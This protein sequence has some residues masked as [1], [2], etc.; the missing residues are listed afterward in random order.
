MSDREKIKSAAPNSLLYRWLENL[1]CPRCRERLAIE[2]L[3]PAPLLHCLACAAHYPVR[4]GIPA[5]VMPEHKNAVAAF[6]EKYEA[7]RLREGWASNIP[8]YY[9]NLP[10]RDLT[11]QHTQEWHLRATSFRFLQKWLQEN[12]SAV[13]LRILDL[14]AGSGWLSRDLATEHEVLALDANAGPHGLAALP[15]AQRH[16]MAVQ[17]ELE[18]LPLAADSFDLV[19]ANAS[20]HYS[21]EIDLFFERINFVLRPGGK[22]VVL[23][24]PVYPT[25]A[26]A[27]AAHERTRVYYMQMGVPELA[28]HYHGL[29]DSI[30]LQQKVF[31]FKRLRS[32][33]SKMIFFK[34]WGREKLG[35]AAAARFP[36]WVGDQRELPKNNRVD[37]G[38]TR[39]V[40]I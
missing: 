19:I 16:F 39:Q 30:F 25:Q 18:C 23:D 21:R 27:D 32:D 31:H 34:K 15:V 13:R 2:T 14:G 10:F 1:R 6:S 28:A 5:L 20:L 8:N 22:F 17:A 36:I 26:A 40:F 29:V 33:F 12:F 24:S 9:E 7:L 38:S 35:G 37:I 3:L 11:E 4:D